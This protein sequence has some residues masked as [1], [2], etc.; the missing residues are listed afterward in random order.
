MPKVNNNSIFFIG[1]EKEPSYCMCLKLMLAYN[2]LLF[3]SV[4]KESLQLPGSVK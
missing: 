3:S 4:F 2:L 1:D